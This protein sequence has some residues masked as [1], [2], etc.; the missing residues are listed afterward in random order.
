MQHKT[1]YTK[2]IATVAAAIAVALGSGGAVSFSYENESPSSSLED[3]VFV[4]DA[5]IKS[6]DG[7]LA[8]VVD[9]LSQNKE[10]K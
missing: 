2:T 5:L 8:M 1:N 6:H 7:N 3:C 10:A 9:S 4:I